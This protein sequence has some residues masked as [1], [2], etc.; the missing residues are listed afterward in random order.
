MEND[1]VELVGD[2][3]RIV[4]VL[5]KASELVSRNRFEAFLKGFRDIDNPTEEQLAKLIKYIDNEQKAEFIADTFQK[6]L[7][8]KSSKSC[9][10]MGT[11]MQ[12]I[13]ESKDELTLE[14]LVC[15]DSLT[16]F[17]D[18]DI[19][20]FRYICDYALEEKNKASKRRAPW[21]PQTRLNL[22]F[23][24]KFNKWYVFSKP[25]KGLYIS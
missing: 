18:F 10:I 5:R 2:S 6:I 24:R 14:D 17:F 4:G 20:H 15:L 7:L 19:V 3:S 23:N 9:L 8:A 13:I 22:S 11:I 12:D 1:Y 21:L 16:N 25:F